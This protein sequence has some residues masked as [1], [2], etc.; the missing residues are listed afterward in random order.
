MSDTHSVSNPELLQIT[1]VVKFLLNEAID[2]EVDYP[3]FKYDYDGGHVIFVERPQFE[4]LSFREK[5]ETCD[6]VEANFPKLVESVEFVD[7]QVNE[8]FSDPF[9]AIDLQ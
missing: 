5:R 7:L 9:F 4:R 6:S 3:Y 1:D 8:D 2:A